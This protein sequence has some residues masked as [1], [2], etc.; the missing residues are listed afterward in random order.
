MKLI[1]ESQGAQLCL[2][3][4]AQLRGVGIFQVENIPG[5]DTGTGKLGG[6]CLMNQEQT[7]DDLNSP[8]DF[9]LH[10]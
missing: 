4:E 6:S 9:T 7:D 8:V 2:T 3:K 5:A 10:K 1:V